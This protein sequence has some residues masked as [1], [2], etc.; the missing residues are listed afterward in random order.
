LEVLVTLNARVFI[1]ALPSVILT[2]LQ[3]ELR[4]PP[5]KLRI[6]AADSIML[7][8]EVCP[9]KHHRLN[10]LQNGSVDDWPHR[11]HVV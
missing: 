9:G 3:S 7:D 10:K 6:Q 2:M 8:R 5:R 11:L 4:H 1:P